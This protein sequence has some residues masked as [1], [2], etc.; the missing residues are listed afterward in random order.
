[1]G[2]NPTL[3]ANR[4]LAY[5][6]LARKWRPQTFDEISGQEVAITILKNAIEMGKIHHGYIFAG[7]RG[8]GKTTLARIFAK[9]LNCE[10]GPTSSPC[11]SCSACRKITAGNFPDV[12]ELDAGSWNSVEEIR[13]IKESALHPP[14]E[15]KYRIFIIDEAHM[16]SYSAFNALLKILEE[17]PEFVIFILATTEPHKI[18]ETVASRT[19][20]IDFSSI[21]EEKV[22]ERLKFICE[23]EG[24]SA[25]DEA[26]KLIA[27]EGKGSLRDSISLLETVWL[28]SGEGK[29]TSETV[30]KALGIAPQSSLENLLKAVF[31][32]DVK[33]SLNEIQNMLIAGF[34]PRK[35]YEE[36]LRMLKD[37]CVFLMSGE[38]NTLPDHT[39]KLVKEIGINFE[40]ALRVY[41]TALRSAEDF[42]YSPSEDIALYMV[43]L[44][45]CYVPRVESVF[46]VLANLRKVGFSNVQNTNIDM[47]GEILK[48]LR[49]SGEFILEA[50]LSQ[51]RWKVEGRKAKIYLKDRR[52]ID[53]VQ[54]YKSQ[55]ESALGIEI[56]VLQDE[57]DELKVAS[58]VSEK[59]KEKGFE[60]L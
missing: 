50:K 8:T 7:T 51:A 38:D 31:S 26:L 32:S 45:L 10:K 22:F 17:P 30:K 39:K 4:V 35:I 42:L 6:S 21:P 43:F 55:I 47:K 27:R 59:A 29:I 34:Q 16:L 57:L 40:S 1:M 5:I 52:D 9:A 24:I 48:F 25:D 49:N 60:F 54:R 28:F 14:V 53:A 23:K 41:N 18:P 44:K 58:E 15:G 3:S 12:F 46:E 56:E 33:S 37:I 2:S 11:N 19:L 13:K 36:F 20:K